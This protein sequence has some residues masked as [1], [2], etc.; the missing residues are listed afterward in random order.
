MFKREPLW[1]RTPPAIFPVCLGFMGLGLAWRNAA[2][3]LP[4]PSEIGDLMLGFSTAFFIYFLVFYLAKLVARPSVLFEDMK[5]PPAR[6]GVAA[7]AMSMMLLAAALLPFDISVP[8]VWWTGVVMQIGATAIVM[9]A[10]WNEPPEVRAFSPFMYV[11][12]VGPVVGPVAGIP[13]G[14]VTE[15][16]ILAS[17][18]MV[19]FIIITIGYTIRLMRVRPPHPLRPSLA[20]FLAPISLFALCFG[21]LNLDWAFWLFYYWGWLVALIL[22]G[23]GPWLTAEGWTPIWGAFTFPIATF[24]NVQ[25]LAY[26]KGATVAGPLGLWAGLSIGTPLILYIVYRSVLAWVTGELAEKSGAARV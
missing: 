21:T 17:A 5:V 14:Y 25:V 2:G 13:L 12:F 9:Y 26:T 16:I 8:Q 3:I 23:L 24:A 22:L 20:I 18:A 4:I 10:I 19:P 15:S 11:T 7:L 6:A 1:R